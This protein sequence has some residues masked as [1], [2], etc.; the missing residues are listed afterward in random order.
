MRIATGDVLLMKSDKRTLIPRFALQ[1]HFLYQFY[2]V[3]NTGLDT[4]AG[5]S[6]FIWYN[7]FDVK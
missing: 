1:I 3:Y 2:N 6:N 5:L 4:L 7:F